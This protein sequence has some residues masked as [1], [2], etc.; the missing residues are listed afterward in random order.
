MPT[1]AVQLYSLREAG[2]L[3]TQLA[4][5]KEARKDYVRTYPKV[6]SAEGAFEDFRRLWDTGFLDDMSLDVRD[7]LAAVRV[8]NAATTRWAC[9]SKSRRSIPTRTCSCA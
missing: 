3:D 8:P 1:A 5:V 4:L 6:G 7:I 9:P 2:D